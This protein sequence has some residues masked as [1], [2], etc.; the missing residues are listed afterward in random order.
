LKYIIFIIALM[1][2]VQANSF[3]GWKTTQI[4][5]YGSGAPESPS[6]RNWDK[7]L[8]DY[9]YILSSP[10]HNFIYTISKE[11][12]EEACK[13]SYPECNNKEITIWE[14]P[15]LTNKA[16]VETGKT[17]WWAVKENEAWVIPKETEYTKY[18]IKPEW[19]ERCFAMKDN[20]CEESLVWHETYVKT[21][22]FVDRWVWKRIKSH[23]TISDFEA[24]ASLAIMDDEIPQDARNVFHAYHAIYY[25]TQEKVKIEVMEIQE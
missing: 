5:V 3:G 18:K 16:L 13:D 22:K 10:D 6:I 20:E 24:E 19:E 17:T 14:H 12:V 2:S 1:F 8:S 7:V 11:K 21:I 15:K 9:D 4:G 23:E 25:Q